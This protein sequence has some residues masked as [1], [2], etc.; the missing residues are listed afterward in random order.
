MLSLFNTNTTE[1]GYR[2]RTLEIFNW[3]TFHEGDSK[4][5]ITTI[6]P[7]GQNT[8]LTG[9][10][11]SGKTTLVDALLVLLVNPTKRF[12][13]Q[14][15]GEKDKKARNEMTYVE[16]HYGRT[17]SGEQQNA[18]VE[19]LRPDRS[20]TYSVILGVFTNAQNLPITL[21]QVRHLN[22][23][24]V[25]CKYIVAKIELS[26]EK[27]IQYSSDGAWLRKL[28]RQYNDRIEDFDGFSKYT[29]AFQRYFGMR[30]EKAMSLFNQTVGMKILGDLDE[31]IRVNMLED[32]EP[33]TQFTKLMESYQTLLESYRALEKAKLQLELLQP[34]YESNDAYRDLEA[35]IKTLSNQKRLLE[36]YFASQ[37]ISIW[38][39]EIEQ[40][41]RKLDG[42]LNKLGKQESELESKR[43]QRNSIEISIANNQIVQ[44]IKDLDKDIKEL[45]KSKNQ[46]EKDLESYNKLARKLEF[47]ENPEENSFQDNYQKALDLQISLKIQ[48]KDLG[49]KQYESWKKTELKEN[50]F[51]I[52]SEEITRL[53]KS[54]SKITDKRI[55]E[56]KQEII[57]AVGASDSEI[58]FVAE[59]IQVRASEKEIW[60]DAVE[61]VLHSLGLCLLVLEKYSDSVTQYIDL[62]KDI[63]G[64]IVYHKVESKV[65]RPIFQD[66]NSRTL[67]SKL[68]FKP[69]NQFTDW[70]ENHIYKKLDY[71]CTEDRNEFNK[72]VKTILPSGTSRNRDRH[73]RDDDPRKRHILGWD[74]RELLREYN[75]KGRE[76]SDEISKL[77]R[78]NDNIQKQLNAIDDTDKLLS[79]FL[80]I[81][82]YSK[83]DWQTDAVEIA[84]LSDRKQELENSNDVYKDLKKQSDVLQEEIKIL[85]KEKSITDREIFGTESNIST[86]KTEQKETEIFLKNY[87]SDNLSAELENIKNLTQSIENQLR[88]EYFFKQKRDFE[89]QIDGKILG[90]NTQKNTA[91][92]TIRKRMNKYRNPSKEITEQ[93]SDWETDMTD[94]G[95]EMED[96]YGYIDHYKRIKDDNLVIFKERFQQEFNK[97]VTKSLTDFVNW[98][99]I[100]HEKI[101]DKITEINDS[102]K[103]IP[104]NLNPDTYIQ[105]EQ[106]KT[107]NKRI[108]EFRFEKLNNWQ[109]DYSQAAM[110]QNMQELEIENFIHKIQPFIKE[111][112]DDERR[113]LEITDVRNWSDFKAKEF[114][115]ADDTQKQVFES[116]TSLSG[117]EAAQLAYTVL[118]AAIAHQFNINKDNTNNRSFRFIVIDE[119]FS[120]LDEDKS[121]YLLKLCKNLG[122]QLM[123]VTPL[124]SIHLAENDISVIHWVAK[125]KKDTRKSV[126]RDIPIL[127]YKKEKENLLAQA[128]EEEEMAV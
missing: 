70:L 38:T 96:L 72:S 111:L 54:S 128:K 91:E 124:T 11:G 32:T 121:K 26:I 60:N 113:R 109:M 47:L 57:D 17:Q 101:E 78:L 110:S 15:S 79:L 77:I 76:L 29:V 97:G 50:D 23:S 58:P 64:K 21:I 62:Q 68:E 45:D 114:W 102:L 123:I 92:S 24:E 56:I 48:K 55:T 43:E 73:E 61:K 42:L 4:A 7:Q 63:K 30:S 44:Q 59:V 94:L 108:N 20:Q 67:V 16:G 87:D 90:V 115:K 36:P 40:Q 51:K 112:K 27:D 5:D 105:I 85:D 93:F 103:E 33:E 122:L 19:K 116:S 1:S 3:G 82:Y 6:S 18:K 74:N 13:N 65:R 28:K 46:K 120:K 75:R 9:A 107:K 39:N 126:V 69:N 119:A 81:K 66:L 104:Y 127:E 125:S 25:K 8:L 52:I 37:Q 22:N 2:L 83:L 99:E 35:Q 100:Q 106:T 117:G 31:F 10:N 49:I 71:L 14:S 12:F 89:K 88:Y 34:V 98:L 86:L 84:K 41:D 80:E 53:Q 118:G 95:T